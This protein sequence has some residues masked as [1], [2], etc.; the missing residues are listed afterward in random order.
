MD[1]NSMNHSRRQAFERM[2][3]EESSRLGGWYQSGLGDGRDKDGKFI[4]FHMYNHIDG[5]SA[6]VWYPGGHCDN[7]D[8]AEKLRLSGESRLPVKTA[9]LTSITYGLSRLVCRLVKASV[10]LFLRVSRGAD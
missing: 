1:A 4:Y 2:A 10:M 9:L 5:R 6:T 7:A 8:L 3:K